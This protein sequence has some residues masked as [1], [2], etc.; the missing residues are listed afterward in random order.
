[1]PRAAPTD[2]QMTVLAFLAKW[3]DE[4]AGASPTFRELA[5]VMQLR[6]VRTVT[7]H[8]HALRAFSLVQHVPGEARTLFL[9]QQGR[10]ALVHWRAPESIALEGGGAKLKPFTIAQLEQSAP[11]VSKRTR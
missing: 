2:R 10:D 11:W 8:V 3:I 4:N 5:E 1:M 6:S 9:T 7:E